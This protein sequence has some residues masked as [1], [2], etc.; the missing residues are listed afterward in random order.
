MN[1]SLAHIRSPA[2]SSRMFSKITKLNDY[3]K[4]T[5]IYEPTVQAKQQKSRVLTYLIILISVA[6]FLLG[7]NFAFHFMRYTSHIPPAPRKSNSNELSVSTSNGFRTCPQANF[8]Y[9]LL[10]IRWPPSYCNYQHC[11]PGVKM[12]DW[13]IH[14]LWP[15]YRNGSYSSFC[16]DDYKFDLNEV[17]PILPQLQVSYF[18]NEHPFN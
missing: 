11:K 3:D 14:G 18:L 16:C 15:D 1:P 13:G 4:V 2:Q 7:V 9:L 6:I 12:Y 10:S 8:D 17:K 5:L